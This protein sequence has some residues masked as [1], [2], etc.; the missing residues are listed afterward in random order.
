MIFRLVLWL[1]I[2]LI[3]HVVVLINT[4]F[5]LWPEMM[6]YPYLLNNEF[7]LYRDLVN[8]YPPIFTFFLSIYSNVFNYAINSYK[9]FTLLIVGTIDVIIFSISYKI[10]RSGPLA[11]ISTVFFVTLSIPFGVNG[12]W[13]DLVQT[14]FVLV[15]SYNFYRF[16]KTKKISSLEIS[17]ILAFIAFFIKQQSIWLIIAYAIT[18][19]VLYKKEAISI[20]TRIKFTYFF[21]AV[22]AFVHIIVFLKQGV[23]KE[24]LYWVVY[25]PIFRGSTAPGY[26]SLPEPEQ[27]LA[28]TVVFLI[29]LPIF[30]LKKTEKKIIALLSVSLLLFAYPRFDYFHLI[31][32]LAI[33]SVLAGKNFMLLREANL[34]IKLVVICCLILSTVFAIR[35]YKSNWTN[36]VRF[37]EPEIISAAKTLSL[38]TAETDKVF[39][40]NGPDQLLP[41]SGKVPPKPWY[42]QFPWYLEDTKLTREVVSDFVEEN[43]SFIVYKPYISHENKFNLGT[44]RPFELAN[45]IENNYINYLQIS[46]T[47]WLKVKKDHL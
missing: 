35:F 23:V 26:Q 43:P 40:Q 21:I 39:I 36:E 3:T 27:L 17:L 13:H 20:L 30:F 15:S 42:I 2:I 46:D 31:P 32:A 10:F 44:Y 22:T 34:F 19:A 41:L 45:F 29:F 4:R 8:P 33:I 25:F 24:F 5:T 47:L 7:W 11:F 14:P 9:I 6:V 38:L 16:V 12:L 1:S 18:V 28:V 37:F